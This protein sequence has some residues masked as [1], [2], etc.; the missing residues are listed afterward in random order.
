MALAAG[1]SSVGLRGDVAAHVAAGQPQPPQRRDHHVG[2]VLAHAAAGGQRLV[3]GRVDPRGVGRV[4]EAAMDRA[5][6]RAG[7]GQRIGLAAR[8]RAQAVDEVEQRRRPGGKEARLAEVPVLAAIAPAVD[9]RPGL[10]AECRW[11][12][13]RRVD[14]HLRP[15]SDRQ[16]RVAAGDVEVVHPVA[17][18]VAVGEHP[19]PRRDLDLELQAALRAVGGRPH[20]QLHHALADRRGVG[21][22][23]DVADRV[24]RGHGGGLREIIPPMPA[25]SDRRRTAGGRRR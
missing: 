1:P 13:P 8:G 23:G 9:D 14:L 21:E 18:E 2:E 17:E 16:L 19:G 20:P 6:D 4:L 15:G 11:Q 5:H 10:R 22:P 24:M 7:G 25:R 12:R 3:D